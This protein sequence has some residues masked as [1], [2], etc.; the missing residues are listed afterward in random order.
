MA[1]IEGKSTD[2]MPRF[3]MNRFVTKDDFLVVVRD[4]SE[5]V[6]KSLEG[7]VVTRGDL[8]QASKAIYDNLRSSL[9]DRF[10][11]VE[12]ELGHR[13]GKV[14][15]ERFNKGIEGDLN[16]ALSST[17]H[18]FTKALD[19]LRIQTNARV[20]YLEKCYQEGMERVESLLKAL[21]I[22]APTVHVQVPDQAPPNVHVE[23]P[24][25]EAPHVHFTAPEIR[26]PDVLPPEITV[27][28][29]QQAAPSVRVEVPKQEP[30]IVNVTVPKQKPMRKSISYD[31]HGLPVEIISQEMED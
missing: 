6:Y 22:P 28:V 10:F 7:N 21:T 13:F 8:L 4:I 3:S 5:R 26:L 14:L 18:T 27:N 17:V 15:E 11:G 1:S 29:P 12:Q 30:S 16:K 2:S 31:Q 19:E 9:E 24:R 23:V 20:A 25:Q